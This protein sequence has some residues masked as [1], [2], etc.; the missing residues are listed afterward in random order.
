MKLFLSFF[1]FA[2]TVYGQT[3]TAEELAAANTFETVTDLSAAEKE[4]FQYLNL[5]RMYPAKY[6]KIELV[7]EDKT[8]GNYKSLIK[9]LNAMV[10]VSALTFDKKA[11][12]SATC[13]AK[14]QSVSGEIGH[15]RKNCKSYFYG[16]CCDYGR[17]DPV[18]IIITLLIDKDIASLGHRKILLGKY[19][20]AGVSIQPHTT[21]RFNTV[22]DFYF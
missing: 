12:E 13:F 14:E 5:A 4:T 19:T 10:P 11:F 15:V 21:Y 22:L 20:S 16:E 8:S 17:N 1:L 3:W 2:T 6:A 18:E 9:T 7:N